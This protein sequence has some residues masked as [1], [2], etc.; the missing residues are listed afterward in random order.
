MSDHPSIAAIQN[1]V[2]RHFGVRV[3]D[4][5]SDRRG[6]AIVWPRHVAIWL[7]R[8]L[9]PCSLPKIALQFGRRDHTTV[10]YAIRRVQDR[11]ERRPD[12][13]SA[14]R[15]LAK[16]LAEEGASPLEDADVEREAI[17]GQLA[18]LLGRRSDLL[19]EAGRLDREIDELGR[20]L[21]GAPE[22]VADNQMECGE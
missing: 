8:E 14:I 17:L 21:W 6:Q 15:A 19:A 22:T 11:M 3:A 13:A 10:M 12:E 18:R 20:V 4:I 5:R 7:C 9:T 1:R 16:E 2:A